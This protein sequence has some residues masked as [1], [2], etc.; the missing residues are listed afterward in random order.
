MRHVFQRAI[1]VAN[2]RKPRSS[3]IARRGFG[4]TSAVV[5]SNHIYDA[6]DGKCSLEM[7]QLLK[8]S[9]G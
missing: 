3:T 8:N 1:F 2:K 5:L 9:A 7:Q 4:Q 6:L